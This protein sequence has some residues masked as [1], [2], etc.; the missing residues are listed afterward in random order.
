MPSGDD[1]GSNS[2]EEM[3]GPNGNNIGVVIWGL[4]WD[5]HVGLGSEVVN[6]IWE[7]RVEP[8]TKRGGI[9]KVGVVELYSS[10]VG[11]VGVDVDV[12]DSLSVEVGGPSDQAV[13]LVAFVE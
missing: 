4:E 10:L 1:V 13:Y 8:A 5:N 3:E 6:L 2:F 7:N 12:V 11:I 9:D